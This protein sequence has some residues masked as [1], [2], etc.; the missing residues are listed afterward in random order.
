MNIEAHVGRL[1]EPLTGRHWDRPE[2]RRQIL[3][4]TRAYLS[5][6][7][8]P[9][10]RVFVHFGNRLEFFAELL[11]IWRVG[12]CAIPVDP[13]LTPYEVAKLAGFAQARFSVHDDA[14]DPAALAAAAGTILRNTLEVEDD[15]GKAAEWTLPPAA[16][17]LDDDAIILFTSGSTGNPKGVVHT[18]RALLAGWMSRKEALGLARY[19]RTLCVVSTQFNLGLIENSLYP[20]LSGCDLFL[21]P[22]AKAD[23]IMQLGSLID[24]HRIE[25]MASVPAIWSLALRSASPPKEASLK[26][27]H[28][29]A[30]PLSASTWRQIQ[31][32]AGTPAV[33]NAYGATETAST[34]AGTNGSAVVPET[35]LIGEATCAA[36]KIVTPEADADPLSEGAERA[37]GETGMI[38]VQAPALMKGYFRRQD[39][40]DAV[41]RQGWF[42]TGD[43]GLLDERGRL[44]LKGR[45]RDEINKG[46]V[47]VNPS[48]VDEVV[49]Q[50]P[51]TKD[52]CTFACEDDFYGENV[53]LAVVLEDRSDRSVIGLY[54]WIRDR[55]AEHTRPARWYLVDEILRTSR[56][57]MNRESVLRACRLVPPLNLR[58][59]LGRYER[60]DDE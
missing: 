31:E 26:R 7:I 32:W 42:M 10:D 2:I 41:L 39:L 40:T 22:P 56:G 59:L 19:R 43:L 11:A 52:V 37:A 12:A 8:E 48:E 36:I 15:F 24:E 6:G 25:Y 51:A 34:V 16:P 3:S 18:H 50:Y 33:F 30:A 47:K 13:L 44:F 45:E 53:G 55:L 21:A 58:E 57:K 38:W 14:S 1:I 17:R 29:A 5:A 49:E 60:S 46:G 23:V 35:G 4:R 28:V 20:W 27:V 9:G 54:D